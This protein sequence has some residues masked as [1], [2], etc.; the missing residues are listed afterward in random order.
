MPTQRVFEPVK[1]KNGHKVPYLLRH[2]SSRKIYAVFRI[3]GRKLPIRRCLETTD[4]QLAQGKLPNVRRE[5]EE[6]IRPKSSDVTV[7]VAAENYEGT[8]GVLSDNTREY[9]KHIIRKFQREMNAV[10][11]AD[12]T[13]GAAERWLAGLIEGG[14]KEDSYNKHL[15]VLR[16]F[17]KLAI[18][19]GTITASPVAHLKCR[20]VPKVRAILPNDEQYEALL[21]DIRENKNNRHGAETADLIEFMGFA[22]VGNAEAEG[23]KWER[24]Y[25]SDNAYELFRKKTRQY[26]RREMTPKVRELLLRRY[27]AS[28]KLGN[29]RVFVVK[30]PIKAI[31]GACKRLQ[32]PSFS[33]RT[34]RKYFITRALRNGVQ[35]DIIA[36]WQNHHD[37]GKLILD[38]YG[39]V[40]PE[41]EKEALAKMA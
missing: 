17:F 31:K 9:R 7:A 22:G 1:L 38:T 12:I 39:Q 10:R 13:P 33:P 30:N 29:S 6:K 25:F 24:V 27:K 40:T 8:L 14:L 16:D 18:R 5:E 41:R 26:Y 35:V 28:D 37:G 36:Q 34:M 19:D 11:L 21:K 20:K 15:N 3:K 4:V 23:L 32:F 2:C